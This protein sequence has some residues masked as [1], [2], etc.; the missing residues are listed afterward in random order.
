MSDLQQLE[1]CRDASKILEKV[2]ADR[3]KIAKW[4]SERDKEAGA[5][6][7]I[8]EKRKSNHETT[9]NNEIKKKYES[10]KNEWWDRCADIGFGNDCNNTT[11]LNAACT[12]HNEERADGECFADIPGCTGYRRTV[13]C[14]RS[15][16]KL[17]TDFN[18]WKKA[19]IFP[20]NEPM[21]EKNKGKYTHVIPTEVPPINIQCCSNAINVNTVGMSTAQLENIKQ[22]CNQQIKQQIEDLKSTTQLPQEIM[23][24]TPIP[25]YK[26]SFIVFSFGGLSS[27]IFFL[28]LI[29]FLLN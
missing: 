6:L 21:P 8:W 23:D 7:E 14:K 9:N 11:G 10:M 2:I 26:N 28:L 3:E 15:S 5:A 13:R 12:M 18:A 24:E 19:Y 27:L 22:D 29:I 20:F 17:E 25:V 1:S 16:S 4:N